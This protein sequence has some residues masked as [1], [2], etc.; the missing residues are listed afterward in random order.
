MLSFIWTSSL[1]LSVLAVMVMSLLILRRVM[2]TG[3]D[4]RNAENR[5]RMMTAMIRLTHDGDAESFLD[6]ARGIHPA[7][8]ADASSEFLDLVRGGDRDVLLAALEQS[9]QPTYLQ[10]ELHR[11]NEVR[12]LQAVELLAAYPA[13]TARPALQE[14]L[15]RD[16]SREVRLAA[17]LELAKIGSVPKL[18][19]LLTKIG[20]RG[21]RSGRLAELFRLLP[22]DSETQLK[23]LAR[24]GGAP[25]FLRAAAL[26]ALWRR[27]GLVE[28]SVFFETA[29]DPAPEVAAAALRALGRVAHRPSLEL[30][31]SK[32]AH[33]DWEVRMEAADAAGRLGDLS[34]VSLLGALLDDEQW[35]VRYRAAQSL[36]QLGKTGLDMLASIA[37]ETPSRRQRT[38]SMVLSEG[39]PA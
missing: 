6:V 15:D 4:Q 5:K 25:V 21:Q 17:A 9:G 3:R 10:K 27:D 1:A 39:L 23:T 29:E 7:V 12:R 37:E 20:Y 32:L 2:T 35:M 18:D 31:I 26:E 30:V 22:D 24:D 36:R 14:R 33:P 34:A 38:A 8:I 16:K 19:R 13:P 11:A 28:P